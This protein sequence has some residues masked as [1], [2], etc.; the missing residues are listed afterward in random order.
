MRPETAYRRV[1]RAIQ[2]S[3]RE[4]SF[5]PLKPVSAAIHKLIEKCIQHGDDSLAYYS[6][7]T[8][9]GTLSYIQDRFN[10]AGRLRWMLQK[11]DQL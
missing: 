1:S 2:R 8:E 7:E 6:P 4:D 9:I 5:A 3:L 10:C 11:I